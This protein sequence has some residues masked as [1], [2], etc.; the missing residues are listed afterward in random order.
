M[1][2]QYPGEDPEE[3]ASTWSVSVTMASDTDPEIVAMA[4]IVKAL[5]AASGLGGKLANGQRWRV[6]RW[7]ADRW[8]PSEGYVWVAPDAGAE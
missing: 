4:L 8:R 7:V 2:I 6:A 3:T 1:P 5:D